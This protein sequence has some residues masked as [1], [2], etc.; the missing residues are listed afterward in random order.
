[1]IV[2]RPRYRLGAPAGWVQQSGITVRPNA[3][4][5]VQQWQIPNVGAQTSWTDEQK[6]SMGARMK[7]ALQGPSFL[8]QNISLLNPPADSEPFDVT[9]SPFPDYPAPGATAITVVQFIVP[10][11][12]LAVIN[13]LSIIDNGGNP[14]GTGSIL[15]SVLVNGAAITGLG[16]ITAPIGSLVYPNDIVL[17]VH[18]QDVVQVDVAVAATASAQTGTTAAKLHGW[19]YPLTQ[20][21]NTQA[22][23]GV[24][25]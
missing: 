2:R 15:W 17:V 4:A 6:L 18:E 8:N 22:G 24:L 16:N 3:A 11:G 7:T 10:P 21:T 19:T 14:V 5:A 1:M 12:M 9:P 25:Q 20:A 13:K 23:S